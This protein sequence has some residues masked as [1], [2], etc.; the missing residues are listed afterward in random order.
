MSTY[1]LRRL[2]KSPGFAAAAVVSI[3]LGIAANSTIFSMVSRFM[4]RPVPVGDPSTLMNLHTTHEGECCNAFSWPLFANLRP[5]TKAFSGVA[6]YYELLPASIG[7]QGEPERVW[8]Q[9]TTANFFDVAQLG[10][11]LGR[12]FLRGEERLPVIVIGHGLWQRR[13]GAD[14]AIAGKRIALSGHPFTVVGVAPAGF[15]GLDLVLDC[16]FW[17]PLG[18]L[19]RLLPNTGNYQSRLPDD[20]GGMSR[21]RRRRRNLASSRGGLRRLTRRRRKTAVS[22]SSRPVRCRR[23]T[24]APW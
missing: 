22:V 12:G 5:Q 20:C 2:A 10:M 15:R 1:A 23:A 13:F 3:G 21:A 14:P 11:T 17:V 16:Q 18:N 7:G 8:G 24:G 6:G 19:D 4:L 9:A